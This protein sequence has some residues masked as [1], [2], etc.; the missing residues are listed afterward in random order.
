MFCPYCSANVEGLKFC[1]QCGKTIVG[2]EKPAPKSTATSPL[3]KP[4]L[5]ILGLLLAYFFWTR[6]N[7]P[8]GL[9]ARSQDSPR[10]QPSSTWVEVKRW[11]GTGQKQTESFQIGSREWR[12]SYATKPAVAGVELLQIYVHE[13]NTGQI[14]TLAANRI[15]SG[16]D[17]SYVQG[18]AGHRYYLVMNTA[19]HWSV[20]IEEQR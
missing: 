8:I 20:L 4:L 18:Q 10:S 19:N 3:L 11:T 6:A 14:V 9:A 12:I 13:A 1:G 5:V 2:N 16:S 7:Q 17:T 15:D